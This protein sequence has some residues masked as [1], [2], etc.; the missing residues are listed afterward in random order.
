MSKILIIGAGMM[1]SAMSL[2]ATDNGHQ[3]HLVGTHLDREIIAHARRK[4][5]HLTMKRPL[6]DAAQ[7]HQLEELDGLIPDTDFVICG[8]SSFGLSWFAD[9]ILPRLPEGLPVLT[10]TKGL[11]DQG[12]GN[13]QC[14]PAYFEARDQHIRPFCAIGGP[15]TSYEL[16]D[17]QHSSVAFCGRD[18]MVLRRL[19]EA[20]STRYYH[21]SLSTDVIGVEGAVALKNAYALAV[22]LALGQSQKERGQ[23]AVPAYN[24]QAALFAQSLREMKGLL[25]LLGGQADNLIWGGGDLYVTVFGGRTRLLGS[26]LGQGLHIDEAMAR[27]QGVTLESV[28]ITRRML[29]ALKERERR[30]ALSMDDYPLLHHVGRRLDGSQED[31]PWAR[32]E[33]VL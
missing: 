30:G 24:P 13:L 2:P 15:C 29:S 5:E 32:F 14:Y 25:K 23:D 6:P 1:G 3:V 4:G 26:L 28:V 16:A 9:E 17:R 27:L 22:T 31:I 20:L 7:F 19:R 21:I 33:Q 8:V 12:D 18:L 10:V 11:I